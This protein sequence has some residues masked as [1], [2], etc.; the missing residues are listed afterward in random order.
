MTLFAYAPSEVDMDLIYEAREQ[1]RRE[2]RM[3]HWCEDCHG[4][5]GPGSPCAVDDEPKDEQE[6]ELT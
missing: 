2:R 3:W 6:D 4:H 5:T 1:R